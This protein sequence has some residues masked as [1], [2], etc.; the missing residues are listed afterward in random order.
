MGHSMGGAEVLTYASLGP[1]SLLSQIRGIISIAPLI[2]LHPSTRPW[3]ST[4]ALGRMAGKLLPRFQLVQALRP[5]WLSHDMSRNEELK[6]DPL[7]HD[8][9]T[10]EGLAGMLDRALSLENGEL[11]VKEGV[12]QGGKSRFVVLHGDDDHVNLFD[13][14]RE[15][16][17]RCKSVGD[18]EF[19]AYRG[20]YHNCELMSFNLLCSSF[21]EVGLESLWIGNAG[22]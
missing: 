21:L 2:A 20:G 17:D 13:A 8:T 10:L 15:F 7:N 4:V 6:A 9:G 12:M 16:V 5:E 18:R 3:R 11:D 1:A 14:S 22:Y 19:R